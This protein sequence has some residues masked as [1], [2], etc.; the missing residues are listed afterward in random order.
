MNRNTQ[1]LYY[2]DSHISEF[3]ATV[4]SCDAVGKDF[5][6]VLDCTAFFP[7][8]GGQESDLGYIGNLRVSKV[9]ED[10]GEIYHIVPSEIPIGS[11]VLCSIDWDTR[12][13]RMQRHSGE[14]IVSGLLNMHYGL[15][16]VGFHM[17]KDD[18]TIDI[19][20]V[21]SREKLDEIE[22]LANGAIWANIPVLSLFPSSEELASLNYR[23]K[24]ELTEDVR[25]VKIEGYDTCACCAP[26]VK[27]T[28]EIGIIKFLEA[29]NYKGGMRIHMLC[30]KEA[31]LDY[32]SR[33]K[34]EAYIASSLSVKQS[35]LTAAFDTNQ[36]NIALLKQ[37]IS[38]ISSELASYKAAAIEPSDN[39]C[40][41]EEMEQENLRN[42]VNLLVP[43]ATGI[44]A[45]F[46]GNDQK[47]YRFIVSSGNIDLKANLSA[48]ND[49]ISGRGGGSKSMIEGFAKGKRADISKFI[50]EFTV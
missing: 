4:I 30:G 21:I 44:V 22:T 25:I 9:L 17:G 2:I 48:I 3:K 10:G 33:H 46:S 7:G 8:G 12:F 23:S 18:V 20:G 1:K 45:A 24:L 16:N 43:K 35:D 39:I 32:R 14:H 49:G 37:T 34:A 36:E 5:R 40:V 13:Q 6:V 47:G 26:H 41:F 28:G 50:N 31:L 29:V 15:D 38:R 27:F 11:E 19:N 42:L